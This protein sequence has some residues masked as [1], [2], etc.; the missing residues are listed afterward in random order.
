MNIR[1]GSNPN[2]WWCRTHST[3]VS[4][5]L[6]QGKPLRRSVVHN[7]QVPRELVGAG[8]QASMTSWPS[9]V[10][11]SEGPDPRPTL[12]RSRSRTAR[13]RKPELLAAS[14]RIRFASATRPWMSDKHSL[15]E[16]IRWLRPDC[17][18]ETL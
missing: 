4:N 5:T 14:A 3:A 11:T 2:A 16:F 17:A 1:I 6:G 7:A 18:S 15:A 13:S 10:L 9:M 8:T 12:C